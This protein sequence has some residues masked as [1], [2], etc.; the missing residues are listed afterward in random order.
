LIE[1]EPNNKKMRMA[2]IKTVEYIDSND[3]MINDF[4]LLHLWAI[5]E[6]NGRFIF[7]VPYG[8]TLRHMN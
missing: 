1:Y 4:D 2:V 8:Y 5:Y 7:D 6:L 3:T